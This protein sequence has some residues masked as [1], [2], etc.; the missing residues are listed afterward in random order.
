MGD[1]VGGWIIALLPFV[2]L[3][4]VLYGRTAIR[5]WSDWFDDWEKGR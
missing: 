5:R 1:E 2:I 4:V 3:A